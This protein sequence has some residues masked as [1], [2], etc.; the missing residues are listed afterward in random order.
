MTEAISK[1]QTPDITWRGAIGSCTF[2]AWDVA[3]GHLPMWLLQM[4][5]IIG[6]GSRKQTQAEVRLQG[7]YYGTTEET[8]HLM[9]P[10]E[11]MEVGFD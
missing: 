7:A 3:C 6:W 1:Q 10:Y 11:V 8:S 4:L 5:S 9:A 2:L